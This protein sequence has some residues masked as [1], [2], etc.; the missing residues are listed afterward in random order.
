M[1]VKMVARVPQNDEKTFQN[2]KIIK[3]EKTQKKIRR[4]DI[5]IKSLS[6]GEKHSKSSNSR[7]I[8]HCFA[9]ILRRS[10]KYL[11][12][13]A[14]IEHYMTKALISTYEMKMTAIKNT[15]KLRR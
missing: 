11:T 4:E 13:V 7:G 15:E 8:C 1:Y 14:R 5:V 12:M 10:E 3:P 9:N 2:Y 6:L